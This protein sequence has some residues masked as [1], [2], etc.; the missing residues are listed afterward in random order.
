MRND[1]CDNVYGPFDRTFDASWSSSSPSIASVQGPGAI[2]L[3]AVGSSTITAQ[4]MGIYYE[5]QEACFETLIPTSSGGGVTVFA[6]PRIVSVSQD[7]IDESQQGG[8]VVEC[9]RFRIKIKY[10]VTCPPV[11]YD[12][13]VL[14]NIQPDA[15]FVCN[16]SLTLLENEDN[17]ICTYEVKKIYRMKTRLSQEVGS[18]FTSYQVKIID[19]GRTAMKSGP[20]VSVRATI[21]GTA[22]CQGSVPCP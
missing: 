13:Q 21:S 22:P 5:P 3:A 19:S 1:P 9:G 18:A 6:T 15:D 12:L 4:F 17:E 14:G 20:G 11:T 2:Y 10:K 16:E 7:I 8:E